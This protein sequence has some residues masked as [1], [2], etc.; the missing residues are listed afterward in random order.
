MAVA[1]HK[2]WTADELRRLPD[3]WRYE[4]DEGVLLI[5]APA[6]YR[7]NRIVSTLARHLGNFAEGRHLGE[8]ITNELGVVLGETRHTLR[9]A[10][11]A[12]FSNERVARIGDELGFPNVPPDLAVEVHDPS[13]P[14]LQRKIGQYL[15]AGVRA[16]WVIDP[17]KRSLTRHAPNEAPRT[18]TDPQ[19][20]IEEPVLPGFSCRLADIF[21]A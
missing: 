7:H 1:T 19:A 2:P 20:L 10:D 6:G 17:D 12:F 18:W 9:A 14:N 16:A 21:G 15:A 8:V 4:I 5:M 3:G 11:I 13:E